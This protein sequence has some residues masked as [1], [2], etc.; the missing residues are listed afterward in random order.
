[1]LIQ[2]QQT[3]KVQHK[4]LRDLN[5]Q[6]KQA[7]GNSIPIYEYLLEEE[8]VLPSTFL[9]Y[10]QKQL[11][12][13]L[14]AFFFYENACEIALMVAP[15]HRGKGIASQLLR[16]LKP[17]V[18]SQEIATLIFSMLPGAGEA[19]QL[20]TRGFQYQSSEYQMLRDITTPLKE[21]QVL[22]VRKAQ[23]EDVATLCLLDL[24]CFPTQQNNLDK[25]LRS[26]IQDPQYTIFVAELNGVLIGKA[27][28][29]WQED[30]AR[31]TDIAITPQLQGLGFGTNLMSHCINYAL[32]MGKSNLLL[33]VETSNQNA[34][35]LYTNLGFF[36]INSCDF[37]A[38]SRQLF[39]QFT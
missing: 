39:G 11:V 24:L 28:I 25:R 17:L 8:R 20:T 29:H 10:E 16:A 1:M 21:Q 37:W 35:R 15:D 22:S 5:A 9:Y 32:K 34:L 26:L 14:S 38:I 33:D 7:D 12:G 36:S 4:D 18:D 2:V 13:F 31:L 19:A 27:H 23:E 6:C 3:S 30:H